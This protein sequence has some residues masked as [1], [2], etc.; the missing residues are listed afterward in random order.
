MKTLQ[1]FLGVGVVI[2][3]L[4]FNF[5]AADIENGSARSALTFSLDTGDGTTDMPA[6]SFDLMGGAGGEEAQLTCAMTPGGNM[7][8]LLLAEPALPR[9]TPL[10][11]RSTSPQVALAPLN[12]LDSPPGYTP[13]R[14]GTLPPGPTPPPPPPPLAVPEPATL[15][16]VGL[17]IG[18]VAVARRR[19]N[20]P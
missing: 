6:I 1:I 20:N 18:A 15:V 13:P 11:S 7:P 2:V 12:S 17:G 8:N 10:Q 4:G 16:L 3:L 5:A 9:V 19:W 14:R